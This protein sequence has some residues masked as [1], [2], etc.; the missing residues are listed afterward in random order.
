[1]K[2][3]L[4]ILALLSISALYSQDKV[5]IHKTDLQTLGAPISK[6]DSV[7]FSSD[8]EI[9]F[10][11][12]KDSL[13]QFSVS[14]ID[15][16]SFGANSNN[17]VITYLNDKVSIINPL[18]FEGVSVEAAGAAVT[19]KSTIDNDSINFIISG[20]SSQG[21]LKIYS[22]KK[23][24]LKLNGITLTNPNGPA[25]NI[26]SPKI[27]YVELIEGTN[28]TIKDGETYSDAPLGSDG[29]AED[30]SAAFFSEGDLKF[31]GSGALTVTGV[32]AKK[33]ALASDDEIKISA[34]NITITSAE[35][36]GI[37]GKSGVEISGG[38]VTVSSNSDAIDG[39]EG[40]IDIS[41]GT[42]II[43]NSKAKANGIVCDSTINISNGNI[44][45]VL[46]GDQAKALKSGQDIT[47]S[48][49]TIDITISGAAVL[50]TSGSGYDPS[51]S[52][53]IKSDSNINLNG[54]NVTIISKGMGGKGIS[55]DKSININKGTLNINCS[56]NGATYKDST[57]TT[58]VYSSTCLS[59]DADIN[60]LGGTVILSNS[61]SAGK[62]VSSDANITIGNM[63][64][65]PEITITTTGSRIYISGNG[66]DADYAEGKALKADGVF[67]M[68]N[69]TLNISSADD[70]VKSE[71]SITIN[72]GTLNITKSYEGLEAPLIEITGGSVSV[73]ASDDAIN[74]T[75][76]N[77]G[78]NSDGSQ[79]NIKGGTVILN[80]SQGDGLDS[81]GDLTISGG[82]TI[83][84]G[85]QSAPEV[86]VDVNGDFKINGGLI[87][88]SGPNSNMTETAEN[89]SAQNSILAK[90]N[91]NT[92]SGTLFHI[93]D[94]NGNNIVTFK[95]IRA[96]STIIFSSPEFI[97][98]T[99]KIMM[100][101]SSTGTS[102]NGIYTN[103]TY[104]GGTLKKTVT[105]SQKVT[106]VSF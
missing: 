101:G 53:G 38:Q 54:A 98:G 39:D 95:P 29:S 94:S 17:I 56:G 92:Q 68:K 7:Y 33:H 13:T 40:Y 8:S 60:I 18:A 46:S 74:S 20:E 6:T 49:G 28:N 76:G 43:N 3:T 62:A 78:E 58:D 100:G 36:D 77:G 24:N 86:G 69:G 48:G 9:M 27:A 25:I 105:V 23:F 51:S 71:K 26:Q 14:G 84:H 44:T 4:L 88:I 82:V 106:T 19:V 90:W 15:S 30:Q 70:G 12:L 85:P 96:Y 59:S 57:N 37:H 75:Y 11:S 22:D 102:N 104:S 34:G 67:L 61:G 47:L 31:S 10:L 21:S 64:S 55:S 50:E 91:Q 1:M 41:G 35:K 81:N 5:Y 45:I 52:T 73:V 83:V 66:E 93:E 103:G 16:V 99:Y 79:I 32:G 42:V 80:A 89:S 63:E 72:N 65:S 87:V 2:N 97:N